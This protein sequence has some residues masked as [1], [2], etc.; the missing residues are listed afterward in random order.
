MAY[1][2]KKVF[3]RLLLLLWAS[4]LLFSQ[5]DTEH[6]FA[7][8]KQSYFT[9]SNKQ[10]LFLSTDSTVPFAVNIYNNNLLLGT[11]TI[12]KGNPVS[13]DIPKDMMMTDLQSGAFITTTRGLY[14]KEKPFFVLSDSL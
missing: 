9:D 4:N 14:V 10:A 3:V 1:L 13:Y 11:V 2:F 12:S 8:M 5:R 6:W 7:P